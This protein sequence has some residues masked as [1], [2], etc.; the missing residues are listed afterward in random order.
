MI[1]CSFGLMSSRLT[2]RQHVDSRIRML[3]KID[4]LSTYQT[5]SSNLSFHESVFLPFTCAHP[6]MPGLTSNLRTCRGLYNS[7][8]SISRGRQPNE[9]HVA[10]QHVPQLRQFIEARI[11]QQ[12]TE[13]GQPLLVRQQRTISCTSVGHRA[14]LTIRKGLPRRPA[15][16][17][18]NS[19]GLPIFRHTSRAI[20]STAKP[21]RSRRRQP[22][23]SRT[24]AS[25]EFSIRCQP[26]EQPRESLRSMADCKMLTI[27]S[28]AISSIS[29]R[30]DGDMPAICSAANAIDLASS[31][32][33]SILPPELRT[34]S[35]PSPRNA[36]INGRPI[37]M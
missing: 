11:A 13:G 17:C 14:E 23:S 37:A 21:R 32:S 8:Y 9:A 35:A 12:S 34:R 31:G 19:T 29:S 22:V 10:E 27:I 1:S 7:T 36:T 18:R 26:L 4:W 6:V 15:R 16:I 30:S 2:T 28:A 20:T 5:S 24:G 3:R 25:F 33:A